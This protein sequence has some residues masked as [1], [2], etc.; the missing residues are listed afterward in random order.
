MSSSNRSSAIITFSANGSIG[1]KGRSTVEW[2]AAEDKRWF[3]EL[4]KKIGIIV[5]GRN[6]F[7]TIG[8][9]PLPQRMNYVLTNNPQDI[10]P[11][12]GS[13]RAVTLAE[14]KTLKLSG[15]CVIGGAQVYETLGPDVEVF[16]ISRHKDKEVEGEVFQLDTSRLVLF[17]RKELSE[18]IAEIYTQP[19]F[20]H[21]DVVMEYD[22]NEFMEAAERAAQF[23]LDKN[24]PT[25]AVLVKEGKIIGQGANG[26]HWHEEHMNDPELKNFAGCRRKLLGCPSGTGYEHCEGCSNDNHAEPRVV[27]D[28]LAKGYNV[29]GAVC[30]LWGHWWCCEPCIKTL[31]ANGIKNVVLSRKWTK[32]FL[33][34]VTD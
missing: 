29:E 16:Y 4:T 20:V 30:Y 3:R 5:M 8:A 11:I 34:I 21:P 33:G 26:S 14:F 10:A 25:S 18:I 32:D 15:Y 2:T 27:K 7:Q 1:P 9:T 24:H 23:S 28:A 12:E 17:N 31:L 13:L 19:A 22:D 6:T